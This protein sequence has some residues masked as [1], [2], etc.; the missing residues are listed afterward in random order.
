MWQFMLT[1]IPLFP[2]NTHINIH[3]IYY[4]FPNEKQ[5]NSWLQPPNIL[6]TTHTPQKICLPLRYFFTPSTLFFLVNT[7]KDTYASPSS[8]HWNLTPHHFWENGFNMV[9]PLD[10]SQ[11]SFYLWRFLLS[12]SFFK[13]TI[14][15]FF[16]MSMIIFFFTGSATCS[17]NAGVVWGSILGLFS[18]PAILLRWASLLQWT[19]AS[20]LH[21]Q[22]LNLCVLPGFLLGSRS[23]FLIV[24]QIF[25]P[26]CLLAC[27]F[28]L[29][30]TSSLLL[31]PQG[32]QPSRNL[33]VLN[34]VSTL[35]HHSP[36]YLLTGST[37][38]ISEMS[39]WSINCLLIVMSTAF[40]L[41]SLFLFYSILIASELVSLL[42]S[43]SF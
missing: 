34:D 25:P 16:H 40:I 29:V 9:N 41:A 37:D 26:A 38:S 5:L 21:S 2:S 42:W 20:P 39:L 33:G 32:S 14:F 31:L 13:M 4:C 17:S 3:T 12:T 23:L 1:H 22:L 30:W 43:L 6:K 24:D 18:L 27:V 15:Y 19:K 8:K 28:T 35:P 7:I 11:S 36:P 10:S